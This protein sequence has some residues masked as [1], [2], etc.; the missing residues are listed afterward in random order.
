MLTSNDIVNKKFDRSAIGGYRNDDVDKFLNEVAH[1]FDELEEQNKDLAKKLEVLAE[2]LEEYR[3]DEESLR[4]ALL[5]AQKL[6][7]SVIRESK[8][9]AEIIMRD[10]TIKAERLINTARD[11]VE[12]EKMVFIKMQKDVAAFKN[13]L[14]AI[15]KQHLE[16]ISSLPDDPNKS[17][18]KEHSQEPKNDTSKQEASAEESAPQN[19]ENSVSQPPSA[20]SEEANH[21]PDESVSYETVQPS[22][23]PNGQKFSVVKKQPVPRYEQEDYEEPAPKPKKFIPVP[24]REDLEEDNKRSPYAEE[25]YEDF[26]DEEDKVDNMESK[27]KSKFG[28]LKFGAGYDLNRE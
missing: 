28:T 5:G 6:G 10:A 11:Q 14:L 12:K 13:K 16:I 23:R 26:D 24:H 17:P 15:Y 2:K 4:S 9:K 7:D 18:A 21:A 22:H 8:N 27:K 3:S 20:V 19:T 25:Y 1:S